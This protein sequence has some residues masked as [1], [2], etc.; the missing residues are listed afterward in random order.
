MTGAQKHTSQCQ[1]AHPPAYDQW[2]LTVYYLGIPCQPLMK[3]L[4]VSDRLWSAHR[5]FWNVNWRKRKGLREGVACRGEKGT[6]P[7]GEINAT[8]V[9]HVSSGAWWILG[10]WKKGM[11]KMRQRKESRFSSLLASFCTSLPLRS[12]SPA[13]IL[14]T[15]F[16][17]V[18]VRG[19]HLFCSV[20][21]CCCHSGD[22]S[23]LY[24]CTSRQ[25]W[26]VG[27]RRGC[28]MG[29]WQGK[30]AWYLLILTH[31]WESETKGQRERFSRK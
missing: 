13:L 19:A 30:D 10:K 14:S 16:L 23:F 1:T 18:T 7:S 4:I 5:L 12:S 21:F 24:I 20:V 27:V 17:M 25:G 2:N 15:P 9:R 6:P 3:G 29:G 31:L 22:A 28:W 11:K 8:R 26:G